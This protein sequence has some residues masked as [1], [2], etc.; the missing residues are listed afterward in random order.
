M[1]CDFALLAD[2]ASSLVERL[3]LCING[4]FGVNI[5]QELRGTGKLLDRSD[6]RMLIDLEN[7]QQ[8]EQILCSYI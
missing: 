6:T 7:K 5:V 3:N 8:E 1:S 2:I 4:L